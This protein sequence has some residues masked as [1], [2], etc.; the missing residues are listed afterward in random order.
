MRL[1]GGASRRRQIRGA[2]TCD[3][4]HNAGGRDS[5]KTDQTGSAM[6]FHHVT[7]RRSHCHPYR[8]YGHC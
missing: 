4:R 5:A 3:L 7:H 1:A 8:Q 2:V 6:C